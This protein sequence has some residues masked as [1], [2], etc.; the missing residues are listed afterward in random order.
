MVSILHSSALTD[1]FLL[2]YHSYHLPFY[3][4]KQASLC[5]AWHSTLW[6][7][8]FCWWG[9][10]RHHFQGLQFLRLSL[11]P[12][13]LLFFPDMFP[14]A[15]S[16]MARPS[17][18]DSFIWSWWELSWNCVLR[19]WCLGPSPVA[20]PARIYK[21]FQLTCRCQGGWEGGRRGGGQ[22]ERM[23]SRQWDSG[24]TS[25]WPI[26]L[27]SALNASIWKQPNY[28]WPLH[29]LQNTAATTN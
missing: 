12:H 21:S 5:L 10:S 23:E 1:S 16:L 29:R 24:I 26:S 8:W 7:S 11:S 14:E 18:P 28:C 15:C 25:L 20:R 3:V 9:K 19:G 4:P 22:E 13:V 6:R 2:S 17:F 27:R